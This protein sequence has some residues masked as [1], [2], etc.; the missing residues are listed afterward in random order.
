[1]A[2]GGAGAQGGKKLLIL[3]GGVPQGGQGFPDMTTHAP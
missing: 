1:M 3:T 2:E